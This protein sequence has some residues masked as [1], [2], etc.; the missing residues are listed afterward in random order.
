MAFEYWIPKRM[1]ENHPTRKF[2]VYVSI[3]TTSFYLLKY[4]CFPQIFESFH[5]ENE[6]NKKIVFFVQFLASLRHI[7]NHLFKFRAQRF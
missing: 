2:P 3:K 1:Y 7:L 4:S 6:D 5:M